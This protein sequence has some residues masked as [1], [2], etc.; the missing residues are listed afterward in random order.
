MR[1]SKTLIGISALA[2]ALSA[3]TLAD[4]ATCSIP[5][6]GDQ[7]D[8][9]YMSGWGCG[10]AAVNDMWSRFSFHKGNWDDGF[11]YE[12]PCNNARPLA[13]TFNALQ[14]MAYSHTNTPTCNTSG[15]NV[16]DW[17]YCWAGN[18]ID[19]LDGECGDG[20]NGTRAYTM[21]VPGWDQYTDLYW[22]F[23]YGETVVQRAGTLFHE[24]RHTNG[25]AHNG[26]GGCPAG[27]DS[28]D[29]A[30]ADGCWGWWSSNGANAY[31]VIYH[32]WFATTAVWT[33]SA[34]RKSAVD[35][36]NAFLRSRFNVDPCFRLDSNGWTYHSCS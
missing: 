25:C 33:T 24:A 14:L 13:R 34:V 12:D 15:A 3:D 28:C 21:A 8:S 35:E 27:G 18:A 5:A 1:L 20:V 11:G 32:Q 29:R 7:F 17:A 9:F 31:T 23:F 22:G 16:L 10:Q 26:Q 6:T 2:S 4:A 30:W 19:E 36:A